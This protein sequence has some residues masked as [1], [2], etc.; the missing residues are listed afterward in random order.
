MARK[1]GLSELDPPSRHILDLIIEREITG[2]IMTATDL[3]RQTKLNRAQ[4]YRKLK[5]LKMNNWVIEERIEHK[6]H[7]RV[8]NKLSKFAN[9][10]ARITSSN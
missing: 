8:S 5:D 9:E 2:E 6:L 7:Y 3:I 4:V 10:L 1:H